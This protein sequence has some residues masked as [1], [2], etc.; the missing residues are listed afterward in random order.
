MVTGVPAQTG[1]IDSAIVRL[2]G[3]TG[4]MVTV[5]VFVGSGPPHVP[6]AFC[7]CLK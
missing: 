4:F 3:K 5:N 1:F 7:S 2:T 6:V